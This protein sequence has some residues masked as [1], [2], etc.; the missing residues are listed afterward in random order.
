MDTATAPPLDPTPPRTLPLP[1]ICET[2]ELPRPPN[3]LRRTRAAEGDAPINLGAL[4]PE[5]A[6]RLSLAVSHQVRE[7]WRQRFVELHRLSSP[8]ARM[9]D[10]PQPFSEPVVR[11]VALRT[12]D[13]LQQY[14]QGLIGAESLAF[15][16]I[17]G[18]HAELAK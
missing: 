2:V 16:F 12:T 4:T 10:L 6:T 8:E 7:H 17:A 1:G 14:R 5:D 18:Y 3:W 9:V 13:K 11:A 15:A